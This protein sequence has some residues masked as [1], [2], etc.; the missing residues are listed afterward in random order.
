MLTKVKKNFNNTAIK[1]NSEKELKEHICKRCKDP[2]YTDR[3]LQNHLSKMVKCKKRAVSDKILNICKCECGKILSC[4]SNLTRHSKNCDHINKN[5][6]I[7]LAN[8]ILPITNLLSQT[9]TV[10]P[11]TRQFNIAG[12]LEDEMNMLGEPGNNFYL[13]LFEIIHCK[14]GRY[15]YHNIYYPRNQTQKMLVYT[16]DYIWKQ[17]PIMEVINRILFT[18]R[19]DLSSFSNDILYD[20]GKQKMRSE[21]S[22]HIKLLNE[23][24]LTIGNIKKYSET[25]LQLREGICLLLRKYSLIIEETLTKT[26]ITSDST[27]D[28][29]TNANSKS[30]DGYS[31]DLSYNFSSCSFDNS[32]DS[33]S[34]KISL[35]SIA[36]TKNISKTKSFSD[37]SDDLSYTSTDYIFDRS[38]ESW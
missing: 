31:D 25:V 1:N 28:S 27:T 8:N 14:K 4:P 37:C 35:K 21:I 15:M 30:C 29:S 26:N 38:N 34:E 12:I 6:Q 17:L 36:K 16:E 33:S 18:I 5:K 23:K 32:S 7:D 2:F 9:N 3:E 22:A 20:K 10:C 24:E 19:N 13:T 11:Y